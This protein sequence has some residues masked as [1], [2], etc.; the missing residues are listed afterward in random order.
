VL[1]LALSRDGTRLAIAGADGSVELWDANGGQRVGGF[2]NGPEPVVACALS[3]QADR[4]VT[5]TAGGA[6]IW[7]FTAEGPRRR[8]ELEGHT[9]AVV[10]VDFSPDGRRV[11]TGSQDASAK[12]WDAETGKALLSLS[13]HADEVTAVGFAADG[14]WLLTAS[15]DGTAI[16]WP[17]AHISP[18]LQTTREIVDYRFGGGPL[19]IDPQARANAPTTPHAAALSFA[20]TIED[21]LDGA[22]RLSLLIEPDA[23]LQAFEQERGTAEV[24]AG[25]QTLARLSGL[26]TAL[27]DVALTEHAELSTLDWII[28]RLAYTRDGEVREPAVRTVSFRL[29]S[30]PDGQTSQASIAVRIMPRSAEVETAERAL[31]RTD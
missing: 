25:A 6:A 5:G 11:V 23:E 30:A 1:G 17:S 16:L 26:D 2:A 28:R 21:A 24:R 19:L 20:A 18:S 10:A 29:R 8:H 31:S 22:E 12:V 4:I 15:R 27:V 7:E 9:A 3:P 13:G 14:R